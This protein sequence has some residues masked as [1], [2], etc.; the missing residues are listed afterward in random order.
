ME[1]LDEELGNEFK[2]VEYNT[3]GCNK[4]SL[5][6]C[7]CVFLS[8]FLL[9]PEATVL[10]T[11]EIDELYSQVSLPL[12]LHMKAGRFSSKPRSPF[13]REVATAETSPISC[14]RCRISNSR[15]IYTYFP[16]LNSIDLNLSSI[17]SNRATSDVI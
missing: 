8:S 15:H 12:W 14:S 2:S 16:F 1:N 9:L 7:V 5:C 6:V 3:G 11:A 13:G 4:S 17:L 10:L